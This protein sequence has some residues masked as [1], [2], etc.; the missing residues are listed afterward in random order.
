MPSSS[1]TPKPP[2]EAPPS[3]RSPKAGLIPL[4]RRPAPPPP[5]PPLPFE[6]LHVVPQ[7]VVDEA[8]NWFA[9]SRVESEH[10]S[11]RDNPLLDCRHRLLTDDSM[12]PVWPT[13]ERSA[14]RSSREWQQLL[15]DIV[16]S[17]SG[18]RLL[19]GEPEATPPTV[20]E[21]T[22]LRRSLAKRAV[23]LL[24]TLSTKSHWTDIGLSAE[25]L[26][27]LTRLL[28]VLV[29]SPDE[30]ASRIERAIPKNVNDPHAERRFCARWCSSAIHRVLGKP[31]HQEVATIVNVI[32]ELEDEVSK[33]A[34]RKA[35][36]DLRP[37]KK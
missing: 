18:H 15:I 10:A 23:A 6:P 34:V 7:C 5:P 13:L 29:R 37:Q 17:V 19:W 32:L 24:E 36:R 8:R 26:A 31:H 16:W 1:D 20:A 35:T 11:F 14:R 27:D 9:T 21:H 22:R 3:P 28:E 4:V 25:E 2:D 12:L 33:D 30:T